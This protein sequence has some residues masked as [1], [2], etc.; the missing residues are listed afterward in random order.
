MGWLL[1]GG[2]VASIG[3]LTLAFIFL[4]KMHTE[5]RGDLKQLLKTEKTL[6]E[7]KESIEDY[8]KTVT[9]LEA[10]LK[11]KDDEIE[12]EKNARKVA[13]AALSKARKK[14]AES[15]NAAAVVE[16]INGTLDELALFAGRV[17]P[18]VPPSTD[19]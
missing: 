2:L 3:S 17:L 6:T 4:R 10:S 9:E 16:D 19:T 8:D 11:E 12:R 1:G 5:N 18:E 15:G 14:L 13:E 7:A